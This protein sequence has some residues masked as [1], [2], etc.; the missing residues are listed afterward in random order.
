MKKILC[1]GM[2]LIAS[3]CIV[4]CDDSS[5]DS[6]SGAAGSIAE[7]KS[8]DNLPDSCKMD[9][10]LVGDTYFASFDNKWVE[11][12]DTATINKFKEGLDD[13]ELQKILGDLE[14]LMAKHSN[15]PGKKEESSSSGDQSDDNSGSSS[16]KEVS[17]SSSSP[18][19]C[20]GEIYNPKEQYCKGGTTLTD[21]EVCNKTKRYKYNPEEQFCLQNQIY[22][23]RDTVLT[24]CG[25][26]EYNPG[27]L[28]VCVN[29]KVERYGCC[30]EQL[31]CILDAFV[32]ALDPLYDPAT[33]YCKDGSRITK[34]PTCASERYN[35]EK[36]YCKNGTT[37]T[38]LPVCGTTK[39]NPEEKF[40]DT[41]S[42]ATT[43]K[44]VAIGG[45]TWMAENL[46]YVTPTATCPEGEFCRS[47]RLITSRCLDNVLSN[48][49]KYGRLYT[50]KAAV[51][52]L[53]LGAECAPSGTVQGV[54]PDG[55]HLPTK[56]EFEGFVNAETENG[57]EEV[58]ELI[59][60]NMLEIWAAG[61]PYSYTSG[62]YAVSESIGR[63]AP[64]PAGATQRSGSY[65]ESFWGDGRDGTY[66]TGFW[67]SAYDAKEAYFLMVGWRFWVTKEDTDDMIGLS[68]RCIK[69]AN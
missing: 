40:C 36:Q 61:E 45:R 25:G 29:G 17:S 21:L 31:T 27:D 46:N 55:W 7:Y 23:E 6:S 11:V 41:R 15:A 4:A 14:S 44:Y 53:D 60:M 18:Q 54:C 8:K 35:P 3:I 43:Y 24:L 51:N 16:S 39:Y 69:N 64:I 67:S 33:H 34:L 63:F 58:G 13:S 65:G 2:A 1:A 50:W 28:D 9:V 37:V 19:M 66:F 56:A 47:E 5:S 32:G 49:D 26:E 12:T 52:C 10:A 68:V 30:G 22:P 62:T 42:P 57:D 20:G 38:T 48:C 59:G